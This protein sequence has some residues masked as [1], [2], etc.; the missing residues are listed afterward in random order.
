V[1][2]DLELDRVLAGW[3]AE[4][5]ERL[6]AEDLSAAL[7][8]VDRTRQRRSLTTGRAPRAALGL[9]ARFSLGVVVALIALSTAWT[10][11]RTVPLDVGQAS[12]YRLDARWAAGASSP[13]VA[14]TALVPVGAP[15]DIYW[16]AA[17]YDRFDLDAWSQTGGSTVGVSAGESLLR[18]SA[19]VLPDALTIPIRATIRPAAFRQGLLLSPGT[20]VRVD[21][22]ASVRTIGAGSWLAAVEVPAAAAY[23]VE[24]RL[25][26]L[27]ENGGVSPARLRAAGSD[28]PRD[29]AERYTAVPPGALGPDARELLATILASTASRDPYDLAVAVEAYLK[30][31]PRFRYDTNPAA[32]DDAS[33]VECLARTRTGYCLHYASTM[34]IMLRSALPDNPV[35]TR[36]VQGFL[37]GERS[38]RVET[39]PSVLAHAWVEVYFEGVGW[40]PFDPTP[41][42]RVTR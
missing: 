21:A 10:A 16:R 5:A 19:E 32:C 8:Q 37:P 28:Y 14:F 35:P 23:T 25:L 6:P 39:V 2:T 3:L 26:R 31:S 22:E 20:P 41:D 11:T 15:Q 33:V 13:D 9:A 38:G 17:T 40:V 27:D 4:G 34:A 42:L 1:N 29:V 12:T 24:A 30:E 18:G 36:L 7:G